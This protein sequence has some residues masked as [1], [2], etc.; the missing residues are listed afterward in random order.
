MKNSACFSRNV[1]DLG[2]AD[3]FDGAPARFN[4]RLAKL[5]A[6]TRSDRY[7]SNPRGETELREAVA[8]YY[9]TQYG[10]LLDP[11]TDICVTPGG[12][13]ALDL[14]LRVVG[15]ERHLVNYFD[16]V[17]SGISNVIKASS[18]QANPIPI[19]K[20]S[21]DSSTLTSLFESFGNS[22][23]VLNNPHN[24]S[25]KIFSPMHL[26][27]IAEACKLYSIEVVSDFV[28]SEFYDTDRPH[29]YL[30]FNPFA[31]EVGSVSKTLAMSGWRCGFI[32]GKGESIR[33]LIGLQQMI[34]AGVPSAVQIA[35]SELLNDPSEMGRLR[36][37]ISERRNCLVSG[38]SRL[39]FCVEPPSSMGT[40][41]TVVWSKIPSKFAT[42]EEV[43]ALLRS[44]NVIC[45]PGPVFGQEG[46]GFVRFALNVELT[47]LKEALDRMSLVIKT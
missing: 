6:N 13:P 42:S 46:E 22:V 33:R 41:T 8:L 37:R 44:V 15:Q 38:L 2:K 14:C 29:S 25:G 21:D 10:V 20:L 3:S 24:P 9:R 12:L 36:P 1:I 18:K 31:L 19:A 16:P 23:L 4:E 5:L 30:E 26:Q 39:G 11:A 35:V 27:L 34:D 40:G 28:F 43:V 17:F 7:P 47:I 32:V 45:L